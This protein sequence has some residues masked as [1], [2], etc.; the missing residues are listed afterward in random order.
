MSSTPGVP[1]TKSAETTSV[2]A[3][4]RKGPST[5]R[6][7]PGGIVVTTQTQT[8][9]EKTVPASTATKALTPNTI[10]IKLPTPLL[11]PS[12][13]PPAPP[14]LA[15][16]NNNNNNGLPQTPNRS[17]AELKNQSIKSPLLTPGAVSIN[18]LGSA[19][20]TPL[21]SVFEAST[22][23]RKE[24]TLEQRWMSD[25][26]LEYADDSFFDDN[27]FAENRK[28]G[29]CAVPVWGMNKNYGVFRDILLAVIGSALLI[30]G[31]IADD[32]MLS[33]SFNLVEVDWIWVIMIGFATVLYVIIR[34]LVFIL[35]NVSLG[36]MYRCRLM[37]GYFYLLATNSSTT[38]FIWSICMIILH[39]NLPYS[40]KIDAASSRV[41]LW[42]LK[43]LPVKINDSVVPSTEFSNFLYRFY[44]VVLVVAVTDAARVLLVDAVSAVP[45]Y[46]KFNQDIQFLVPRIRGFELIH[47]VIKGERNLG[48]MGKKVTSDG[49][50]DGELNQN[51]LPKYFEL[52]LVNLDEQERVSDDATRVIS[53]RIHDRKTARAVAKRLY[54]FFAKNSEE[55]TIGIDLPHFLAP[56]DERRLDSSTLKIEMTRV[57]NLIDGDCSGT[58]TEAEFVAACEEMQRLHR[59]I[60]QGEVSYEI[61]TIA[62]QYIVKGVYLIIMLFVVLAILDVDVMEVYGYLMTFIA[63]WSFALSSSIT[64]AVESLLFITVY[65]TFDVGD[66]VVINGVRYTVKEIRFFNTVFTAGTGEAVYISNP[67]MMTKNIVNRFRSRH[68]V[69]TLRFDISLDTPSAHIAAIKQEFDGYVKRN[70]KV[71]LIDDVFPIVIS[72]KQSLLLHRVSQNACQY[73][74][75]I[76]TCLSSSALDDLTNRFVSTDV[77]K[78]FNRVGYQNL[79]SLQVSSL[80]QLCK[81]IRS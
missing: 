69:V 44:I 22:F 77:L 24:E 10:A 6:G 61:G 20:M 25:L 65:R 8:Q 9:T 7:A 72:N 67:D 45:N 30:L 49:S 53:V 14:P 17:Y 12:S 16:E 33:T 58:I 76:S 70:W 2:E 57:F 38:P 34:A 47:D 42:V 74:S 63:A 79:T 71:S 5:E 29:C 75:I 23:E 32:T 21:P 27:R 28:A 4:S 11:G 60:S 51:A 66:S 18:G 26:L 62:V 36:L 37:R 78:Y 54:S 43:F 19:G 50:G 56:I 55:N 1:E 73:P 41:P 81:T 15:P 48:E 46:M 35:L 59:N 39:V 3:G 13:D 68:A 80:M 31:L 64:R 52:P 40:T